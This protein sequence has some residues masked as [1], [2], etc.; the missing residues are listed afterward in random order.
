MFYCKKSN[1]IITLIWNHIFY[2]TEKNI[3]QMAQLKW[4]FIKRALKNFQ[5]AFV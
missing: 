4:H 2:D 5:M 1:V 3:F